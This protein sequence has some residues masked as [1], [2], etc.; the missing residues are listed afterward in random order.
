MIGR[1]LTL[2]RWHLKLVFTID[3]INGKYGKYYNNL[4]KFRSL[5][6]MK[7]LIQEFLVS[8]GFF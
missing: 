1:D 6:R 7:N 8:T 4:E 5:Y 3:E 2:I